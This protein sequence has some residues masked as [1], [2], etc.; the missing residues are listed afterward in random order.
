MIDGLSANI[1]DDHA[2]LERG[3][4]IYDALDT[5]CGDLRSEIHNGT[6]PSAAPTTAPRAVP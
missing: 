5:W 1:P 6:P 3:M 4:V 2:M